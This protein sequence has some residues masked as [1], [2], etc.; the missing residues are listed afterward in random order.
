[1]IQRT[2]IGLIVFVLVV[3]ID[4]AGL[5]LDWFLEQHGFRSIT[6]TVGVYPVLGVALVALQIL[7]A[8]GLAYHFYGRRK[9]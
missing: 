8:A 5:L 9:P 3:C 2:T 6:A 4:A 7:G 1:M